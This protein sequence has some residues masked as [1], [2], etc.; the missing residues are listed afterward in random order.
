MRIRLFK[1]ERRLSRLVVVKTAS[2]DREKEKSSRGWV[3]SEQR[4]VA[5]KLLINIHSGPQGAVF[6]ISLSETATDISVRQLFIP[7]K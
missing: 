1:T 7:M 5:Y 4:L 3:V 6:V 2:Q